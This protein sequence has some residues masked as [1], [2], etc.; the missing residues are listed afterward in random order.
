M[1]LNRRLHL[2]LTVEQDDGSKI[3]VHTAPISRAVYTANYD[4]IISTAVEL[5]GANWAPGTGMRVASLRMGEIALRKDGGLEAKDRTYRDMYDGLIN[6]IWRLTNFLVLDPKTGW[7]TLP[8]QQAINSKFVDEDALEEIKN[9]VCFFTVASWF[10]N[11]PERQALYEQ[12]PNFGATTTSLDCTAYRNTLP[13]SNKDASSGATATA[14]ST[15][16]S[17]A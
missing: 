17:T 5:Y 13:M 14:S 9:A 10:H 16:S 12:M 11:G 7:Q 1:K 15:N 3:V 6:E 8:L 4:L 2:V